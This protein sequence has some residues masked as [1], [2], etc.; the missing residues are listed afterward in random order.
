[1]ARTFHNA[2]LQK[3]FDALGRTP[4]GAELARVLEQKKTFILLTPLISGGF[5][6]NLVNTIAL[7][8]RQP[9]D[10]LVTLLAHEACHVEQGFLVDSVQQELVSYR[11]Q[12]EVA[13][14]VACNIGGMAGFAKFDPA[15]PG[16][17]QAAQELMT[18]LFNGQPAA[19][20]YAA[21]PL[22]QPRGLVAAM[23]ALRQIAAL[24]RAETAELVKFIRPKLPTAKN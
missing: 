15:L 10:Y 5:T 17:L 9:D 7:D 1:M 11:T 19:V 20:L 12:C 14:Q 4:R 21:M 24:I 6:L 22:V 2:R 8:S 23:P 13:N 18:S 3:T 16:D